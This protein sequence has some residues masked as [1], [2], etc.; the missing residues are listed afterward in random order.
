MSLVCLKQEEFGGWAERNKWLILVL[1]K[2]KRGYLS[3]LQIAII[4]RLETLS[5]QKQRHLEKMN[6]LQFRIITYLQHPLIPT[7]VVLTEDW[8]RV[9]NLQQE[10]Q[11]KGWW[12]LNSRFWLY[13][14]ELLTEKSFSWM[15]KVADFVFA[16]FA[17]HWR[18]IYTLWFCKCCFLLF[19]C[20]LFLYFKKEIFIS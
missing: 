17:F 11:N 7:L 1:K 19:F 14:G 20:S 8:F 12:L 4:H 3:P 9:C 10:E 18:V 16:H 6:L 2:K 5:G 13:F 15:A